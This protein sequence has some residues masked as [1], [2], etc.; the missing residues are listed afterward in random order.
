ME[1]D[2]VGGY[3]ADKQKLRQA[4][5]IAIDI[6][7]LIQIFTNG[8][9]LPAQNLLPPGIFG[10]REGE[11]GVNRFVYDWDETTAK[12]VRKSIEEARRL[13]AEAG[14]P[15][16]KDKDG[17]PLVLYFDT[18]STG[19][20]TKPRLDWL[21]KQFGK[22]NVDLQIRQTDY[23]RFQ[24]KVRQG[25]FQILRWGWHA[26]YPDPENFLFLLYGPNAKAKYG[27]E[28]AGNYDNAEFNRLFKQVESM[29]NGPE[30]MKLI[31][32]MLEIVYRDAPWMWGYHPISFGL[33]HEWYTNTKPMTIGMNTLKY[34]KL[35]PILREK[36]RQEWN[37]PIWWVIPL[38]FAVLVVVGLPAAITIWKRERR[39]EIE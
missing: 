21:R 11:D 3:T 2:V 37:R 1:D 35:H 33:Y 15:D 20:A 18:A 29:P 5:S 28:N 16:G 12:P 31:G 25:N 39:V 26:D 13:L 7:E 27:G 32:Q 36:R 14:Y 23:N 34:K 4:L 9:G 17:T 24:D 6:E 10:H 19:A 38:V 22:L 8:R 30:R